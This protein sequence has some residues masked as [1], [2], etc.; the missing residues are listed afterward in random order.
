MHITRS[1]K[2]ILKKTFT[3]HAYTHVQTERYKQRQ[4]GTRQTGQTGT[5]QTGQTSNVPPLAE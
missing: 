5:R 4:T 1:N 3:F 2:N